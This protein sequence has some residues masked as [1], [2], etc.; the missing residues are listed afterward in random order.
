MPEKSPKRI[1][2]R[3]LDAVGLAGVPDDIITWI[4][5]ALAVSA[6]VGSFFAGLGLAGSTAVSALALLCVWALLLFFRRPPAN[7]PILDESEAV[8][9]TADYGA[10][11]TLYNVDAVLQEFRADQAR[12]DKDV[13]E[14]ICDEIRATSKNVYDHDQPF[15]SGIVRKFNAWKR[16]VSDRW[17]AHEATR[18]FVLP[19]D[20]KATGKTVFGEYKRK[21]DEM[22]KA[23]E[24][25]WA[26]KQKL[27]LLP[28]D[29]ARIVADSAKRRLDDH[30]LWVRTTR[31]KNQNIFIDEWSPTAERIVEDVRLVF[32]DYEATKIQELATPTEG[33]WITQLAHPDDETG[34]NR[35]YASLAHMFHLERELKNLANR[36]DADRLEGFSGFD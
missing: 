23:E 21:K 6:A 27:T 31:Q 4:G 35:F 3:A 34:K 15:S 32:G 25:L 12:G 30:A 24:W 29:K 13:F 8:A 2:R 11:H 36:V 16:E 17:S 20:K 7:G 26:E 19:F 10:A 18:A 33:M 14:P 5:W 1:T 28:E 9:G 22:R